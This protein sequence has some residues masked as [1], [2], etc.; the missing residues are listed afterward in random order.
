MKRQILLR[1][2]VG[3]IMAL[4]L[5]LFLAALSPAL[6]SQDKDADGDFTDKQLDFFRKQVQ[7]ILKV[8]C[9]T[10]H[11][12]QSNSK[13][14]LHLVSRALVLK[15]GESGPALRRTA[16][17]GDAWYPIGNNPHYPLDSIDRF[18]GGIRRLNQI[19][20][21]QGRDPASISLVYCA[22]WFD[23]SKTLTLDDGGR[24]LLSGTAQ[25]IGEDIAAL[26]EIGVLGL[27]LNFQRET[28][29]QSLDAMQYFVDVI[30]PTA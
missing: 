20:T 6:P 29:E 16:R 18:A 22:L 5:A 12:P 7:P 27:I 25:Q 19:A 23:E 11:G 17:Y 4:V 9:L 21:E 14:E 2:V 24:H 15:G 26:A 3:T 28:L 1:V 8:N 30:Y 10:R 13:G